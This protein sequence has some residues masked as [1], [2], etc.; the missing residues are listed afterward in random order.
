MST[1]TLVLGM[2]IGGTATRAVLADLDGRVR[3]TGSAG[4]GN[5]HSH[6]LDTA[7]GNIGAAARAALGSAETSAVGAVVLG[8]A[9]STVLTSGDTAEQLHRTCAEL[10]LRCDVAVLT[11]YEVAF[12]AGTPAPRGAVLIAGT[13]A[14]AARV[15]QHRAAATAGGHGWLLGDEG[16]AFWIGR[17]AVRVTLH[18]LDAGSPLGA[19]GRSV[20]RALG[21][22]PGTEAAPGSAAASAAVAAVH[23][24]PPIRL[25]ELAPLVTD[26][27]AEDAAARDLVDR[28][29]RALADTA[30]LVA[31]AATDLVL[32]GGLTGPDNPVGAALRAELAEPGGPVL[33][34]AG[35]GAAGAAWLAAHRTSA[36]ERADLPALHRRLVGGTAERLTS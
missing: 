12:A 7:L 22:A 31:P 36:A 20:L 1:T 15:E 19:L 5:P 25:A 2:D 17:E 9:G 35:S 11:D 8:L 29:A 32:A 18:A 13:G 34:T 3:G 10:G 6:P 24:A 4:G 23:A 33:R 30:R 27:V 21:A 26:A 16:S 28:A 14:V